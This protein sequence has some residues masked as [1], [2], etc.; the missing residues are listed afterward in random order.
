MQ[1]LEFTEADWKLFRKRLPDWQERYMA[2]LIEEYR[3][4]LSSDVPASSKFWELDKRIKNDKRKTGVLA[5]D[6][7]RSNMR[8]LMMD[9][10]NEGAISVE[11]FE[12]FSEDFKAQLTLFLDR[13]R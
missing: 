13:A 1:N 10:I 9:L 2:S 6:V 11:D 12:G 3:T 5:T 7:S 8:F 4:F